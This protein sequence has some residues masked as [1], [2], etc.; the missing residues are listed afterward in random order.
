MMKKTNVMKKLPAAAIL[1]A[2][3]VGLLGTAPAPA[4]AAAAKATQIYDSPDGND[5][6]AFPTQQYIKTYAGPSA[7]SK[8]TGTV[9]RNGAF[10]IDAR[11]SNGWYRTQWFSTSGGYD[12]IRPQDITLVREN[13]IGSYA[14]PVYSFPQ[15]GLAAPEP[16]AAVP[17]ITVKPSDDDVTVNHETIIS[18]LG[19][20]TRI[21][22][23]G[24]DYYEYA[25]DEEV[26]R[27]G[28]H[29]A[30]EFDYVPDEDNA[31]RDDAEMRLLIRGWSANEYTTGQIEK[32]SAAVREI[33]KFYYPTGYKTIYSMLY[34]GYE[35]GA[36]MDEFLDTNFL[37]DN[38]ELRVEYYINE[39][40]VGMYI[41]R[42]GMRYTSSFVLPDNVAT[43]S[44]NGKR[45]ITDHPAILEKGSTLVP[46][47]GIFEQLG[48][49]IEWNQKAQTITA[50]KGDTKI[51]LTV[52]QKTAV[53]NGKPVTLDTAPKVADG[54]TLVPLR[55]I[56]QSLGA[57]VSWDQ[58]NRT[59]AIEQNTSEQE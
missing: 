26:V 4:S 38:R 27:N 31:Y 6:Y 58:E 9:K 22:A 24:I 14:E 35:T 47:R 59:A 42:T 51:T 43:V 55:F 18:T 1:A 52:G 17:A 21:G 28:G 2:L 49:T 40:S 29:A 56:S 20:H 10:M 3:A 33:L 11:M 5:M 46:M 7:T 39:G 50:T 54:T 41:G 45:L 34:K 8:V 32:V 23:D 53:V 15:V 36:D 25:P 30:L 57:K 44:V 12:Y 19:F 16:K 13:D 37:F 48:A